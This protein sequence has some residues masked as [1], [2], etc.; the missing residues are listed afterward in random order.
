MRL[1]LDSVGTLPAFCAIPL[2]QLWLFLK[3]HRT[4]LTRAC[5]FSIRCID[6]VANV[7]LYAVSSRYVCGACLPCGKS[8]MVPWMGITVT[9][10]RSEYAYDTAY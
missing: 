2:V 6:D 3:L 5:V 9:L 7:T 10:S 4:I 1:S 8:G